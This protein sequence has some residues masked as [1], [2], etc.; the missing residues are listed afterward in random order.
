MKGNG[1][2]ETLLYGESILSRWS[3]S[4]SVKFHSRGGGT[5]FRSLDSNLFK[6]KYT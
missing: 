1:E 4:I 3:K 6:N 2:L 5:L